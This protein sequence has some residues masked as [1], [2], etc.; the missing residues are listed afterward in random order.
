MNAP[1]ISP[2]SRLFKNAVERDTGWHIHVA[3]DYRDGAYQGGDYIAYDG[4]TS[5]LTIVED[6]SME[7]PEPLRLVGVM[8]NVLVFAL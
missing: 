3:T 2:R 1:T 7:T 6:F 8:G 4:G 5:F